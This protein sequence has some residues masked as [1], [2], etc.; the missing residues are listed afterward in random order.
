[1]M[2]MIVLRRR[3]RRDNILRVVPQNFPRFRSFLLSRFKITRVV[4]LLLLLFREEEEE[5]KDML[6]R[7]NPTWRDMRKRVRRVRFNLN[8]KARETVVVVARVC[9][10]F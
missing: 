5:D 4:L 1:M 2:M 7:L 8:T 6:S 10:N 9:E 3:R